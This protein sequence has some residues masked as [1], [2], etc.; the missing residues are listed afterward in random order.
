MYS[1]FKIFEFKLLSQKSF[2]IDKIYYIF[3]F[4]IMHPSLSKRKSTLISTLLFLALLLAN[5]IFGVWWPYIYIT[6][7]APIFSKQ[8]LSGRIYEGIVSLSI[9]GGLFLVSR[10]VIDWST[11]L[12]VVFSI[13]ALMIIFREFF[14]PYAAKEVELEE[15]QNLETM[16]EDH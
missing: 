4:I 7:G 6:I 11:I 12:P 15:D 10:F 1:F 13:S 8:F 3:N 2:Y 14:N 5:G 9:F 16:E